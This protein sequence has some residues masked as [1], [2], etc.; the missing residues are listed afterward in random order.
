MKKEKTIQLVIRIA[1]TFLII[2]IVSLLMRNVIFHSYLNHKVAL[3]NEEHHANLNIEDAALAGFS[4]IRMTGISLGPDT[5]DTLLTVDS[6]RVTLGFWKMLTGRISLRS[7]ETGT[8]RI[9]ISDDD[10]VNNY[11]FLF[12]T[13][14][15]STDTL[16]RKVDYAT[17][18]D[19]ISSAVFEKLPAVLKIRNLDVTYRNH[20]HRVEMQVRDF[21]AEH[22]AF[23]TQAVFTENDTVRKWILAGNLDNPAHG[24]GLRIYAADS[25]KINVPYIGYR[26]QASVRFDT[27]TMLFRDE[28]KGDDLY[29]AAC[30][31]T[32]SGL[33]IRQDKVAPG[34]VTFDRVGI[35]IR[36]NAG[37]DFIEADSATQVFVNKLDFHPYIR[38]AVKP[39]KQITFTIHKPWFEAQDLFSSLPQGLFSTLQGVRVTGSLAFDL[40][41]FVDLSVP[42][43]L[44]F[45]AGLKRKNFAVISYGAADL[46][47]LNGS[48]EYTPYERGKPA[49]PFIVGPENPSFRPLHRISPFFQLSVLTSED[50]GFFQHRGFIPEA[51]RESIIQNIKERKFARGAS[52]ITMQL[53]KNVYL[54]RNK[55]IARKLEEILLVWLLENQ[56][57]CSKE[58]MFE[59]YLNIM[60]LG[61]GIYGVNPAAHFYFS[62]DAS[63]LTL[64]ESIFLSSIIPKPKWFMYSF[65]KTGH[66]NPSMKDYYALLAGKML[67]KGQISQEEY[68]RLIP[69]VTLSGPAKMLLKHDSILP[70]DSLE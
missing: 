55:N 41:F 27:L 70:A 24:G 49:V 38:Y 28:D 64:Q 4:S 69:D 53:V 22:H 31:A 43:S 14:R 19:R 25:G 1:G 21:N 29:H 5:G 67:R 45:D 54:N 20:D 42:D 18:F 10:T 50:P 35:D 6:A 61:P 65:D 32:V 56:E 68:D 2:L 3:F 52:T 11:R 7:L 44:K 57:L 15:D 26:Y 16:R 17:T 30:L 58:R 66:L 8:I 48:F 33:E 9:R 36:V 47:K 37:E 23:H 51:F 12:R 46:A 39:A 60:E 62:K 34:T 59:V 13:R 40:D 63:K